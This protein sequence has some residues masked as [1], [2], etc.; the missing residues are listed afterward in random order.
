[1]KKILAIVFMVVAYMFVSNDDYQVQVE[2]NDHWCDMIEQKVWYA[3][4]DE[5]AQRCGE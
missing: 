2:E 4:Q 1:M 5:I 3:S